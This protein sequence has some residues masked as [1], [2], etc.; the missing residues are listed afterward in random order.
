[1]TSNNTETEEKRVLGYILKNPA[2]CVKQCREAGIT[3]ET[4][5]TAKFSWAFEQIYRT[6]T[7]GE[8]VDIPWLMNAAQSTPECPLKPV[9]I[10]DLEH[11]KLEAMASGESDGGEAAALN[12]LRRRAEGLALGEVPLPAIQN[13]AEEVGRI[14]THH[15]LPPELVNGLLFQGSKMMLGSGSKSFKTWVLLD[16]AVSIAA[17]VPFWGMQTTKAKVLYLN[18]ELQEAFFWRRIR[19]IC[20]AKGIDVPDGL[21][22]WNLRGHVSTMERMVPKIQLRIDKQGYGACFLDPIYKMLGGKQEN[23]AGDITEVMNA[24]ET[25]ITRL[26]ASVIFAA[27]FSKG[28]QSAK[29]AIDRVSGSGAFARD[30]DSIVMMTRH[31]EEDAFSIEAE[32]RNLPRPEPFVVRWD[33]PL[34][35]RDNE[36]DPAKLKK[37]PGG[38]AKRTVEEI[39]EL[40]PKSGL[41][42]GDW[43][44]LAESDAGIGRS[45]FFELRREAGDRIET[46]D[47]K[48]FPK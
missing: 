38:K 19:E 40:L 29:E 41:S 12:T 44:K 34:T 1:M 6:V 46:H 27:H 16:L 20:R 32:L 3:P 7:A 33:W 23:D 39:L 43:Q 18:L 14:D 2:T 30:P 26:N 48:N 45:R 10:T 15:P 47:G 9:D 8:S 35:R 42:T 36:L 37:I 4:F 22:C 31:E 17:G 21:D 28:N 11:A 5:Q 13:A 24:M 25:L